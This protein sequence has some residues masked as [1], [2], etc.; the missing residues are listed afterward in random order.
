MSLLKKDK[1]MQASSPKEDKV[2][3]YVFFTKL[4]IMKHITK[5]DA[6]KSNPRNPM[7]IDRKDAINN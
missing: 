4:Y 1:E 7:L 6:R 5:K 3:L 2:H